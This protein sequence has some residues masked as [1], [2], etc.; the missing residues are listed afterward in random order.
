VDGDTFGAALATGV[1]F[2]GVGRENLVG[3]AKNGDDDRLVDDL[4][5]D[6]GP[7]GFLWWALDGCVEGGV[8]FGV[9]GD[10]GVRVNSAGR[11]G[12]DATLA[13]GG[14]A[15]VGGVL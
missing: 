12:V 8:C 13:E 6:K 10:F 11:L 7:I 4:A 2:F 15:F 5:G 1:S 9:G 3:L 14:T